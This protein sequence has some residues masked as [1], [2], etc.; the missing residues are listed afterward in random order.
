MKHHTNSIFGLGLSIVA[1]V[2]LLGYKTHES[3]FSISDLF[4][5]WDS[6]NL[7]LLN[8]KDSKDA[9]LCSEPNSFRKKFPSYKEPVYT[10]FCEPDCCDEKRVKS[11]DPC[12]DVTPSARGCIETS[13]P[14][15]ETAYLYWR[16]SIENLSVTSNLQQQSNIQIKETI[17]QVDYKYESGFKLGL[18]YNLFYDYWDIFA[19][20]TRLHTQPHSSWNSPNQLLTTSLLDPFQGSSIIRSSSVSS[21]GNLHFDTVDLELGRRLFLGRNL[22]IRPYAGL[23]GA[24][25]TSRLNTSYVGISDPLFNSATVSLKNRNQ[26]V[27]LRFG[28]QGRWD[29]GCSNFAILANVAGAVLW[30][31]IKTRNDTNEFLPNGNLTLGGG[32]KHA[33][34]RTLTP[35]VECFIGLDWGSCFYKKYYLGISAGYEMQFWW[36]YNTF[37]VAY[38]NTTMYDLKLHGLTATITID[39]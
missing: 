35:L 8:R 26:G 2:Y 18:G 16:S 30:N 17:K 9:F 33:H 12:I 7:S 5:R 22:A 11:F 29:L 32:S 14:Y 15:L 37:F 39:F 36:D 10:D 31:N 20:W 21:R 24:W 1:L 38:R 34:Y 25:V 27:G 13:G 28:M 19:N 23:K 6:K 3:S 4:N